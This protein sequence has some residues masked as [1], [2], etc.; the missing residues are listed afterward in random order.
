[1]RAPSLWILLVVW[2]FAQT[3]SFEGNAHQYDA[4]QKCNS[5]NFC[6][7]SGLNL[8][9]VPRVLENVSV[10][11]LSHNNIS[12]IKD[13]DFITY[14]KL[15][16]LLLQSN[17]IQSVADQAFQRNTQL[18]YLDL[19]N[20][21]LT[22]LSPNWFKYLSKLQH[23][24]ILGNKY[25]DLGSGGIFSNLAQLRWLEF[26]NPSLSLLK[27]DDFVGVTHLDEFIVKA[28]KLHV[29]QKGSFS[30]FRNISHA[31]LSLHDTFLNEPGQAQQILLDLSGST[32][33]IELRD[34]VFPD[35]TDNLLFSTEGNTLIR[36]FTF[37]NVSLTD[38]I[39]VSFINSMK[40]TKLSELVVQ[41]CVLSGTGKWHKMTFQTNNFLQSITISNISIRKFYLFYELSG[42]GPLLESIKKATFTKLMMFLMPCHL[43]RKLKNVEYLDLTDN[44]L[45]DGIM[46]ETLCSGAWSSVRHLILRKNDF[47]DLCTISSKL[48]TL[49]NLT[50]LDLSQNRFRD[51]KT[52]CKWSENLQFLNLSSCDIKSVTKSVPPNVE[53]LDLS[54]NAI[55]SF[56][57]N[58]SSLKELNV[59]NNKFKILPGDGYL[60]KMEI[61]KISSNKLTSLTGEEIK[62]FKKLQFLEAGKNNY[63]CSCDFL[64]YMNN[65]ITVQLLGGTENYV[66]DSPLFLR[67]ML[68]QNTK[69]SFFD[70]HTTLSLTLLCV[71]I[72]LAVAIAGMMCYKYHGIW[73]IQMIWAWLKAKR[74]PKKVRNYDLCYDAFV[75]YSEMDSEWVENFLV[76]EL[77]SAH[78]PLTLC[79][80]K[81]DFIPGKWIIDNIIESIEK[82]RKSLFV[83]SQHFVQSEWCKYEL[84]YTHFRLFDEN[85]DTAI[86]V[87][88]ESI[89]KETIPQR[90]CKLRKLM[91]TKTYLEWPQDEEEQPIF[92]FNL[93]IALQ[94]DSTASL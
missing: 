72:F 22:Q 16:R 1:M 29:Y 55:S 78:P 21:L 82:S 66:C 79:L 77:E 83:L 35:K 23:L 19:S 63:I 45:S 67:G 48:S 42:I 38:S 68:V 9:N 74:K 75:S 17:Q 64:F 80:H 76:R 91:N 12:Q 49:S 34:L 54:N 85:D 36:K 33:H 25:T 61:L 4:C 81:R 8:E 71:G 30:S 86:L 43:S 62:A 89:P 88:L 14:V 41:D 52:S 87:L 94:G 24:N 10:F 7:C 60:P 44:L 93:R 27:K 3:A 90:F 47:K 15:K 5:D 57:I 18:E 92:W 39:V 46:P 11:D 53:V 2:I 84:D 26:G 58:A 50:H 56:D 31:A 73:Y 40:N 32:I 13:T 20:N 70:C 51:I 65:D 37:R 28:E 69:R 6:N 59:S